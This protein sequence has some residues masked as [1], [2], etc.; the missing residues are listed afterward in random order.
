MIHVSQ[1]WCP[2][3][4]RCRGG[5][6]PLIR[7]SNVFWNASVVPRRRHRAPGVGPPPGNVQQ[8][9]PISSVS[10]LLRSVQLIANTNLSHPLDP[11]DPNK[12][13]HY[14]RLISQR[15]GRPWQT[16]NFL[17]NLTTVLTSSWMNPVVRPPRG[18]CTM[19]SI[20]WSPLL[21]LEVQPGPRNPKSTL[22]HGQ[23]TLAFASLGRGPPRLW[24]ISS[25]TATAKAIIVR[26][27]RRK[28]LTI[29]VVLRPNGPR[30]NPQNQ[31]KRPG[32]DTKS[33]SRWS[34]NDMRQSSSG[35]GN[36]T[37]LS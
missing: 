18:T 30:P 25:T 34:V 31:G 20:A 13:S 23:R 26:S 17:W 3:N 4:T 8:L 7:T 10:R 24:S 35:R 33:N 29:D 6:Q 36:S 5:S 2:R 14:W 19:G 11:L 37:R 28:S 21:S 27:A 22:R 16:K 15:R 1:R 12:V 9:S 32:N